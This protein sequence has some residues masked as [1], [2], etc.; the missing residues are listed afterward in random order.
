MRYLSLGPGGACLNVLSRG[1]QAPVKIVVSNDVVREQFRGVGFH[2]QLFLDSA[3][4]E[5]WTR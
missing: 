4:P 2:G 5:Y 3:T 1:C